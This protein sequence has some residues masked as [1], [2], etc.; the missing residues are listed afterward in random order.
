[1]LTDGRFQ[2]LQRLHFDWLQFAGLVRTVE[3]HVLVEP[4]L[5]IQSVVARPLVQD[6]VEAMPW[7]SPPL[8]P[9]VLDLV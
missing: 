1:M 6:E 9:G 5:Y 8:L 3:A 2:R 4:M 7:C